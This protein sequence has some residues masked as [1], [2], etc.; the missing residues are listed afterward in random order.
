MTML[1]MLC[2]TI[3]RNLSKMKPKQRCQYLTNNIRIKIKTLISK[4]CHQMMIIYKM[5]WVML[6]NLNMLFDYRLINYH[7]LVCINKKWDMINELRFDMKCEVKLK[8]YNI[9]NIDIYVVIASSYFRFAWRQNQ[10]MKI[11]WF[12]LKHS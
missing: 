1:K 7:S 10:S 2:K 3:P 11:L 12:N 8:K 9:W 6:I 5:I 4:M